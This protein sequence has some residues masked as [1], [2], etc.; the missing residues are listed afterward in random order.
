METRA[1]KFCDL[2]QRPETSRHNS[3][4]PKRPKCVTNTKYKIPS[5]FVCL[6]RVRT[7]PNNLY[8]ASDKTARMILRT[9]QSKFSLK[10]KPY[11]MSKQTQTFRMGYHK[12]PEHFYRNQNKT[13]L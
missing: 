2:K 4:Y 10:T 11:P 13:S 1:L 5:G 8:A 12:P 9:T 6:T 3:G 7:D